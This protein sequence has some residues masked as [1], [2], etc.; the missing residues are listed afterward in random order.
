M[1]QYQALKGMRD[2]LPAEVAEWQEIEARARFY[3]EGA[4]FEEIRTPVLES[5]ELFARSIGEG[6]DIV[7]KQMYTFE[8][9]GGRSV[10]LRPEMTASVVRAAVENGLLRSSKTVRLYYLGPMFRAERPQ[11]GRQRQFFQLGAEI[12]NARKPDA[13]VEIISLVHGLLAFLGVSEFRIKHNYLGSGAERLS[14]TEDLKGYFEKFSGELCEDCRYRIEKNVLRVLDCKVPACQS[15]IGSAPSL[16][17][18]DESVRQYGQI[19][20]QLRARNIPGEKDPRLVRGLDYY[21]GLVFE[22]TGGGGLGSQDAVA[23]GGRYDGLIPSLGGG[24]LGATGF[25]AGMERVLLARAR[26]AEGGDRQVYV[27]MLDENPEIRHCF[28]TVAE[29]LYG[30]GRKARR[31]PAARGLADHLKTANKWGVRHVIILGENEVKSRRLTVKDLRGKAQEEVP[32][33]EL[34][35]YLIMKREKSC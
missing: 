32:M 33:E 18:S 35:A 34:A 2:I 27:A 25:A 5:T 15:I 21:T 16:R 6:S 14:Y 8:D 19:Q 17:L 30:I 7:H 12:L 23:A 22:V 28:E 1:S 4:G 24:E 20:E 10:T 29:S 13:D 11:K 26:S 9:R 3:F 31:D